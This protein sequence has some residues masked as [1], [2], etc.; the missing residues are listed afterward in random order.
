R[1]KCST[2]GATGSG[3][4]ED[5]AGLPGATSFRT[6]EH[7]VDVFV[8]PLLVGGFPGQAGLP[9][10]EESARIAVESVSGSGS[11]S[12]PSTPAPGAAVSDVEARRT[13]KAAPGR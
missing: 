1:K 6:A 9:R 11:L 3:R 7:E 2:S 10:R 4:A 5:M 12:S 13:R 8:H